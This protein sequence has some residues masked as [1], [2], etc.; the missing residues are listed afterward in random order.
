MKGFNS[1][2]K[3]RNGKKCAFVLHVGVPCSPH[4][5]AKRTCKGDYGHINKMI[6]IQSKKEIMDNRLRD[7]RPQLTKFDG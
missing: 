2:N 7:L 3:V 1:W 5:N 6:V 4:N